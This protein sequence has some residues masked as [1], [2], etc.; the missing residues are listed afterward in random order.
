MQGQKKY[1]YIFA[2][3]GAS[4]CILV[5]E[6]SRKGLLEN[7]SIL[8]IDPSEKK[9]ND[10]TYC[11]WAEEND[12]I[13]K[14]F[15]PLASHSW[16]KVAI[17]QN[18]AQRI[19]P[20]TYYHINSL[21]L[22]NS[23]KKILERHNGVFLNTAVNN[24][25]EQE[26]TI[27]ETNH[28]AFEGRTIYDGRPPETDD[29]QS[30]HQNILQSF[31]GYKIKLK[32]SKLDPD[33]CTLMDFNVAQQSHTQFVYVLP[34]SDQTALVEL[35]R[36]GSK[37]ISQKESE[38][39]LKEYIEAHYGT[40][41]VIGTEQGVI[42]MF[43]DLAKPRSL[44]NVVPIGTRANKVKPSTGYAFKN[45][46]AHS[47]AI[48]NNAQTKAVSPRFRLYD[49]LLILILALWPEKGRPIFQRLF[50][51]KKTSYVLR[52]LDE[53]TSI[54]EDASMF[55]K[56]PIGIFLK[57][58]FVLS[59]KKSRSL[60]LLFGPVLLYYVLNYFSPNISN[61]VLY[62]LLLLGLI[63]VGIPHG[64]M[65][66]MT[67]ALSKTKRITLP[68]VIKYLGLMAMVYVLWVLSP[69]IAV[70]SFILYSAWHFGETDTQEWGIYSPVIGLCWGVLF[71]I[72]LFASHLQ[73]LNGVLSLLGA[74]T[75]D[76][77]INPKDIFLASLALS[78]VIA[79]YN[80]SMQWIF[81]LAFLFLSQWMPLVISFGIYFIFHHSYKGWS[82][83]KQALGESDVSL[84]KNALP[85]N[86]GAMV[87]F[88]IFFLNP[89]ATFEAN[90][91]VFFVFISCISF[92]HIFCMHR[93]YTLKKTSQKLDRTN[94]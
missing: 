9:V 65:D 51:V 50:A 89:S 60:A 25:C 75:I 86:L 84:F 4:S 58:C 66:H 54:W 30:S 72:G 3:F 87:L 12:E 80:K 57:A 29:I 21:D 5:H 74:G 69:G 81:L 79:S 2:G 68:F 7:K 36:F 16:S 35:T 13:I 32:D 33:A 93:F 70:F 92:P 85:F 52:F 47:K 62:I 24:I 67:E 56:L 94:Q 53:K 46:Y 39:I 63:A 55:Y 34:F 49:R 41:E 26:T 45:M 37:V 20:L 38:T 43:M 18:L 90:T 48:T 61:I 28:G 14:D 19:S 23:A 1:D 78:L 40:Y 27:I 10:K 22:Y 71:F 73:E 15:A 64:A 88:F 42:P 82:H 8:A 77:Y 91:S 59:I 11:F 6:L 31:I 17:D 76:V 83:L 44:K